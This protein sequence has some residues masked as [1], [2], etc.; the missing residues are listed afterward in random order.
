[1]TK[2]E[3]QRRLEAAEKQML[4]LQDE[5]QN[6]KAKLDKVQDGEIPEFP[7]FERG[8]PYYAVDDEFDIEHGTHSGYKG[9]SHE[10]DYLYNAF[11]SKEMAQEFA[12]KCKLIAM[13]LHCK[14]YVDRDYAPNWKQYFQKK[15]GVF[16]DH[17]KSEYIA[18][19]SGNV[20][21][22]NDVVFSTEIAAHKAANWL[23][24]RLERDKND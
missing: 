13:L 4:G 7:D 11:H 2:D 18:A 20:M 23:N 16:Y 24:R 8:E 14:W 12:K 10:D 17:S 9:T 21:E 15:Y 19:I 5:I 6:L 3:I 22:S 1:M